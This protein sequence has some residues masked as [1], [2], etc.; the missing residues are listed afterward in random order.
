MSL[1]DDYDMEM[2]YGNCELEYFRMN[3]NLTKNMSLIQGHCLELAKINNEHDYRLVVGNAFL[4]LVLAVN[5]MKI[6]FF[7][8]DKNRKRIKN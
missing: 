7:Y 1:L 2:E 6:Y 4:W 8:E 3:C 5:Y